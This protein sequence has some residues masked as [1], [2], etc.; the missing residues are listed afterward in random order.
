MICI[1]AQYLLLSRLNAAVGGSNVR[2]YK[3]PADENHF[4]KGRNVDFFLED[5]QKKYCNVFFT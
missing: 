5:R 1:T 2:T 3:P 4:A